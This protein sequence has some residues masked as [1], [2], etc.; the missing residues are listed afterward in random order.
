MEI[1]MKLRSQGF[2]IQCLNSIYKG[3][4]IVK[5]LKMINQ[6]IRVLNVKKL[7]RNGYLL[8][9]AYL[10]A[11][12]VLEFIEDLEFRFLLLDH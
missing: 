2:Q 4:Q 5:P 11:Y 1:I 10:F 9:T 6:I 12:N 7:I 8:I 3:K